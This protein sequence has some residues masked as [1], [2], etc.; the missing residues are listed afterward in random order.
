MLQMSGALE[1]HAAKMRRQALSLLLGTVSGSATTN[2]WKLL[3][4][5][6]GVDEDPEEAEVAEAASLAHLLKAQ[7]EERDLDTAAARKAILKSKADQEA[8][9]SSSQEAPVGAAKRKATASATLRAKKTGDDEYPNKCSLEQAQ[10]YFP[11]NLDTMHQTGVSSSWVGDRIKLGGYKGCYPCQGTDCEYVAQTR[12][13]LCT[14]VRRVHLGVALGCRLC[15]EKAWWQ[16]RYWSEHMEKVHPDAPK[17]EVITTGPNVVSTTED[18][19]DLYVR[20]ET[21]VFPPPES[22]EIKLETPNPPE[23]K[24]SDEEPDRQG[25]KKMKLSA[26]NIEALEAG[27]EYIRADPVKGPSGAPFP[28]IIGIRHRKRPTPDDE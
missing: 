13:V 6:F 21:M 8:P 2:L 5:Y 27:A 10:L 7:K 20:E 19:V 1:I 25:S 12:G 23:D 11:A 3:E 4:H 9:T 17:F 16:A 15:P 24:D 26:E 22:A 18:D 14:H 28:S